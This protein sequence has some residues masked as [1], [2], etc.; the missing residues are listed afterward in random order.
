MGFQSVVGVFGFHQQVAVRLSRDDGAGDMT[1]SVFAREVFT[2]RQQIDLD[3]R[4]DADG[5]L[6]RVAAEIVLQKTA[7]T[8][9]SRVLREFG[10]YEDAVWSSSCLSHRSC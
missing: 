2:K 5:H 10:G 9:K 4:V 8:R 6:C 1:T 7:T 3:V